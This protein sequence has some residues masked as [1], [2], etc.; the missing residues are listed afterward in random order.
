MKPSRLLPRL[1]AGHLEN[2]AFRDFARLAETL[3]FRCTRESGSHRIY[4]HPRIPQLINLQTVRGQAK[5]YQIRQFLRLIDRYNL[6][7]DTDR[8]T[9]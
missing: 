1:K 3:G 2:V 4:F 5:P 6:L 9:D 7:S 8:E